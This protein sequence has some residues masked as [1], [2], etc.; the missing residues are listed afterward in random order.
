MQASNF[1]LPSL[2]LVLVSFEPLILMK[3]K[4]Y[5]RFSG[6]TMIEALSRGRFLWWTKRNFVGSIIDRDI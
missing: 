2:D 6:Y 4:F 3:T 1:Y 5:V